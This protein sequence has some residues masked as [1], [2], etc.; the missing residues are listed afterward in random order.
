MTSAMET[1]SESSKMPRTIP[2]HTK[3]PKIPS[4]TQLSSQSYSFQHPD[5]STESSSQFVKQET[6]SRVEERYST[7]STLN[8]ILLESSTKQAIPSFGID[9]STAAQKEMSTTVPSISQGEHVRQQKLSESSV[10]EKLSLS[11]SR[12]THSTVTSTKLL[13]SS[14]KLPGFVYSANNITT[15][16]AIFLTIR[17]SPI[18]TEDRFVTTRLHESPTHPIQSTSLLV[19]DVA[20][21]SNVLSKATVAIYG[22]E[23]RF[24][25]QKP[26]LVSSS[27]V[28]ALSSSS[29]APF[30]SHSMD[31]INTSSTL[32]YPRMSLPKTRY[33]VTDIFP[34]PFVFR[35]KSTVM[36]SSLP[37]NVDQTSIL[38]N[39]KIRSLKP[40]ISLDD[41]SVFPTRSLRDYKT[42]EIGTFARND[43]LTLS[44]GS[45]AEITSLTETSL[46][47]S[48]Q[49]SPASFYESSIRLKADS[50]MPLEQHSTFLLWSQTADKSLDPRVTSS[51]GPGSFSEL[52]TGTSI[53]ENATEAFSSSPLVSSA[54]D[55]SRTPVVIS[56]TKSSTTGQS[57]QT[58]D[59]RILVSSALTKNMSSKRSP[60]S[61]KVPSSV[62]ILQ[63]YELPS[64]P[65]VAER[66]AFLA[67]SSDTKSFIATEGGYIYY[68][69]SAS[70]LQSTALKG[71]T[72]TKHVY[73]IEKL[74]SRPPVQSSRSTTKTLKVLMKPQATQIT[75]SLTQ[76][77]TKRGY[78]VYFTTSSYPQLSSPL[79]GEAMTRASSSQRTQSITVIAETSKLSITHLATHFKQ[80][81]SASSILKPSFV[82]QGN[83]LFLPTESSRSVGSTTEEEAI[84]KP[85]HSLSSKTSMPSTSKVPFTSSVS[86]VNTSLS[87]SSSEKSYVVTRDGFINLLASTF[88]KF[89]S[90]GEVMTSQMY[91]LSQQQMLSSMSA[92]QASKQRETPLSAGLYS[93]PSLSSIVKFS[94]VFTAEDRETLTLMEDLVASSKQVLLSPSPQSSSSLQLEATASLLTS[95]LLSSSKHEELS[96]PCLYVSSSPI[97]SLSSSS[98]MQHLLLSPF[99]KSSSAQE[100]QTTKRYLYSVM[101]S[102]ERVQSSPSSRFSLALQ[103]E[104]TESRVSYVRSS[105]L[106]KHIPF[107]TSSLFS[108]SQLATKI[109]L[110]SSARFTLLKFSSSQKITPVRALLDALKSSSS[111]QQTG[112]TIFLQLS[113]LQEAL[114][115]TSQINY[116]T[117]LSSIQ[118]SSSSQYIMLSSYIRPSSTLKVLSTASYVESLASLLPRQQILSSVYPRVTSALKVKSTIESLSLPSLQVSSPPK[119]EI[120]R[121]RPSPSQHEMA[122]LSSLPASSVPR[123][124][125]N[126]DL[127]SSFTTSFR[128]LEIKSS[129]SLQVSSAPKDE[130]TKRLTDSMKTSLSKDEIRSLLPPKAS[131]TFKVAEAIS[132]MNSSRTSSSKH[133]MQS[134]A[135]PQFSLTSKLDVTTSLMD[136]IRISLSKYE[137]QPKVSST[138]ELEVTTSLTDSIGMSLSKYEMQP[139][140]S[141]KASSKPRSIEAE[142]TSLRSLSSRQ[143]ILSSTAPQLSS[144][145]K[146]DA[147]TSH[148]E[149]MS[150][151]SFSRKRALSSLSP[152]STSVKK[153][154]LSPSRVVSFTSS[155]TGQYMLLSVTNAQTSKLPTKPTVSKVNSFAIPNPF[156]S[157]V[158]DEEDYTFFTTSTFSLLSPTPTLQWAQNF[159][160]SSSSLYTSML[161]ERPTVDQSV[162]YERRFTNS[163]VSTEERHQTVTAKVDAPKIPSLALSKMV[164]S[165]LEPASVKV[166]SSPTPIAVQ[167]EKCKSFSECS[168]VKCC[169]FIVIDRLAPTS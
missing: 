61:L 2:S 97:D 131:T 6:L 28:V 148:M 66:K 168:N 83:R 73:S 108:S 135:S 15:T 118:S 102:L 49:G 35:E 139:L 127:M 75:S 88:S 142:Y 53:L 37:F 43:S 27:Q 155:L 46:Q 95:K 79:K 72:I 38:G 93:L 111:G 80:L 103:R 163:L 3:T 136:S 89:S 124:E 114:H 78:D 14:S 123:V 110:D 82:T 105:P 20:I 8:V 52:I 67:S 11:V 39:T 62:S 117:S 18:S 101:S 141:P 41:P 68:T 33:V 5:I 86:E 152:K 143:P 133:D 169:I 64:S 47:R 166:V 57:N 91:P 1:F 44:L 138:P 74:T 10:K 146:E 100:V 17:P 50:T 129:T 87:F 112:N 54:I 58:V 140:L 24:S 13:S 164:Q 160:I 115:R 99:S 144:A 81:L 126:T 154:K 4:S 125:L 145:L 130:V 55:Y 69:T 25:D 119:L 40:L 30:T 76:F 48:V 167:Q 60:S 90:L 158:F 151:S 120:T 159:L 165:S 65:F 150:T 94:S 59:V 16:V 45:G 149:S 147:T 92:L 56:S 104:G 161:Q 122:P 128:K 63:T 153:D 121:S 36:N 84:T 162:S 85:L 32:P 9:V 116:Q 109:V 19:T 26:V 21:P 51:L 71:E 77:V 31:A 42:E 134:L 157:S 106:T 132:L 137:M 113:S 12:V 156:M 107:S 70:Q 34:T 22:S 98:S 96:P 29:L 7:S 23:K